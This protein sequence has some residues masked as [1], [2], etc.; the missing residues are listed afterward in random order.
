MCI[1]ENKRLSSVLVAAKRQL[2][3]AKGRQ[4]G[5]VLGSL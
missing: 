4:E 1:R 3:K 2:A 5:R